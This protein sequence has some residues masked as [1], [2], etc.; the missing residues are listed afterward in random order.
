MN[1]ANEPTRVAGLVIDDLE[2]RV[3]P[4]TNDDSLSTVERQP[5]SVVK[6]LVIFVT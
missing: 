3:T 1:Q 2:H 6:E 5:V 4:A